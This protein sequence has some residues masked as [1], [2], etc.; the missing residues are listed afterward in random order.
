MGDLSDEPTKKPSRDV[1]LQGEIYRVIQLRE[2]EGK[3]WTEIRMESIY[4]IYQC[5]KS[6]VVFTTILIL[7]LLNTGPRAS[8]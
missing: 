4:S 6:T 7:G 8:Y 3:D 1:W 2:V 5:D